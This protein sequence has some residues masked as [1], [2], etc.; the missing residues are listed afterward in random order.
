MLKIKKESILATIELHPA[1]LIG[2]EILLKG[3]FHSVKIEDV[4]LKCNQF[5]I[6]DPATKETKW[7]NVNDLEDETVFDSFDSCGCGQ[8]I[9]IK[10]ILGILSQ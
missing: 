2:R 8:S 3:S 10:T 9:T 1:S 4:N 5:L 7:I 6:V